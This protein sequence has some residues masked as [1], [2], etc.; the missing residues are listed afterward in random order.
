MTR[1]I[2][3]EIHVG[4]RRGRGTPR[5]PAMPTPS[6]Q[7]TG[8]PTAR[9]RSSSRT[10]SPGRRAQPHARR[11]ARPDRRRRRGR[12]SDP[13]SR[14]AARSRRG[15]ARQQRV[16]TIEQRAD[17]AGRDALPTSRARLGATTR[18]SRRISIARRRA[19]RHAEAALVARAAVDDGDRLAGGDGMRATLRADAR[20]CQ[21]NALLAHTAHGLALR[22]DRTI[23]RPSV[24]PRARPASANA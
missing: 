5:R 12:R 9:S 15:N 11:R 4:A 18:P 6:P 2:R 20:L 13:R 7:R 21:V 17:R 8:A 23:A 19:E 3:R 1:V 16:A 10:S 22:P 24:H 14:R